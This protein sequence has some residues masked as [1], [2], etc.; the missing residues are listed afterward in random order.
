MAHKSSHMD[1][2]GWEMFKGDFDALLWVGKVKQL[3]KT[4]VLLLLLLF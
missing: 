2:E 3:I 1:T 4:N